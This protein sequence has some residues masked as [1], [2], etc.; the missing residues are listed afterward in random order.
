[1]QAEIS[2]QFLGEDE[3]CKTSSCTVIKSPHTDGEYGTSNRSGV[4]DHTLIQM[5]AERIHEADNGRVK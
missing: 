1:M 4:G 2:Y 5:K 3:Y